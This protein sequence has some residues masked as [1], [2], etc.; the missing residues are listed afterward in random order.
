MI[1]IIIGFFYCIGINFVIVIYEF[2]QFKYN[3]E[4]IFIFHGKLNM[5]IIV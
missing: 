1:I 4:Y 3:Y 5:L 2:I